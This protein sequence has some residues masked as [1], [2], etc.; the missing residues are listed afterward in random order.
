MHLSTEGLFID[1]SYVSIEVALQVKKFAVKT[2]VLNSVLVP[3]WG[4]ERTDVQNLS[5]GLHKCTHMK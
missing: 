2:N 5:S 4:K 3:T 1:S